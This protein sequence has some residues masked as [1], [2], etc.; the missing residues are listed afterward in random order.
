MGFIAPK[1]LEF[2]FIERLNKYCT[3]GLYDSDTDLV[4]CYLLPENSRK[5]L[6]LQAI[7]FIYDKKTIASLEALYRNSNTDV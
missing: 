2:A 6:D 1:G 3:L 7:T 5:V 4:E